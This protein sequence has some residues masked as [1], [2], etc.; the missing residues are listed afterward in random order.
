M[1]RQINLFPYF[2]AVSPIYSSQTAYRSYIQENKDY[3]VIHKLIFNEK[4]TTY[5]IHQLEHFLFHGKIGSKE[6]F[7]K[8]YPEE[9]SLGRFIRSIAGLDRNTAKH[10]F[11]KYLDKNKFSGN[12]ITFI[13]QIIDYLTQKGVLEPSQLFEIPFDEIHSEGITGVF[14]EKTTDEIIDMIEGINMNAEVAV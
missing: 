9:T 3:L 2:Q 7:E 1:R 13:N 4:I 10:V 8:A 11:A 12:Q 5:D 6:D 14:D